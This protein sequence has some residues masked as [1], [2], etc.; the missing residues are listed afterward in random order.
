[1]A[2]AAHFEDAPER[3]GERRGPR[4]RLRLEALGATSAGG[5]TSVLV[6]NISATGLLLE[7]AVP[8]AGGESISIELPHAG[9]TAA[10]VIWTSGDYFGCQFDAPISAAALSAAELRGTAAPPAEVPR[11]PREAPSSES[12]GV[13]LQRLRKDRGLTL[14]QVAAELGVSKPTVW[15]WENGRARPV[16]GRM[17]A[18]A[19]TLGVPVAALQASARDNGELRDLLARSREQ[20]AEAFGVGAGNV[21]IMIEL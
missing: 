3:P 19:Q 1:M 11:L 12:F 16:D 7:S 20:I 6:H 14:A 15:A 5:A 10:R 17:E 21:R 2:I 9:P 4:R 8:L 18:L 13:R